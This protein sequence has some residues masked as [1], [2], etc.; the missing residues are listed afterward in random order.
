MPQCWA[1][2]IVLPFRLRFVM[3]AIAKEIWLNLNRPH[4]P[5][6]AFM[7]FTIAFTGTYAYVHHIKPARDQAAWDEMKADIDRNVSGLHNS[8]DCFFSC[9]CLQGND[10]LPRYSALHW[11]DLYKMYDDQKGVPRELATDLTFEQLEVRSRI[12][13][14]LWRLQSTPYLFSQGG[15]SPAYNDMEYMDRNPKAKGASLLLLLSRGIQV[16]A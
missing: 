14:A 11:G 5:T 10:G 12:G 6:K 15:P 9:S 8:A 2:V 16:R 3:A 4:G 1:F 7:W 13:H